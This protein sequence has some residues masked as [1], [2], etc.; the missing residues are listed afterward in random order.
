MKAKNKINHPKHFCKTI[1]P[2]YIFFK[3]ENSQKI[4]NKAGRGRLT[5]NVKSY[6]LFMASI[7]SY[8]CTYI[9]LNYCLGVQKSCLGLLYIMVSN[10]VG[11]V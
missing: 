8:S 3:Q 6:C 7:A 2:F 11:C 4:Y 1:S 9:Y 5:V 10:T